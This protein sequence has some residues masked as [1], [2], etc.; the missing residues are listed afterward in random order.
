MLFYYNLILLYIYREALAA[1]DA[2]RATPELQGLDQFA[3]KVYEWVGRSTIRRKE[4]KQLLEE[5]EREPLVLLRFHAVRWLSRG[6]VM[7]R[8]LYVMPAILEAFKKEEPIWYLKMTSFQFQFLL[9]LLVDVLCELNKL[10][11]KFQ[12]DLV[13]I[14][15]IGSSLEICTSVLRRHFLCGLGPNFARLSKHLGKF[16]RESTPHMR[17]VFVQEDGT[18]MLYPLHNEPI[19]QRPGSLEECKLIAAEYVQHVIDALNDRF[20]DLPIFNAAKLFSPKHYPEDEEER[21]RSTDLWLER[22]VNKFVASA[23]ERDL[24][25]AEMLEFIETMRYECGQKS[26]NEAWVLCGCSL[27][28]RT[29]WPNLT[30]LWQK[31]LVIP[32]SIAICERGFSKQNL[33]KSALRSR[34]RLNT[35]D[36]LMRVSLCGIDVGDIDWLAVMQE[37]RNMRDRRILALD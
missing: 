36:A 8:I 28:W 26:I 23:D 9:Y 20:P 25:R 14:T 6:Q 32:S 27:E 24:C 22:L 29:N 4:L 5:F 30:R 19:C 2:S 15:A 10:N 1:G 17:L 18:E 35:L 13:D 11:K 3:T 21:T 33:V 31:V 7:E 16:L 12:Y 34:L 37:W